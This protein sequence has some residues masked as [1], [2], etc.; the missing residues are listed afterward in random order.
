MAALLLSFESSKGLVGAY[1]Y[2]HKV[3]AWQYIDHIKANSFQRQRSRNLE[4]YTAEHKNR[5]HN[6]EPAGHLEHP[7]HSFLWTKL[8]VEY[9]SKKRLI[10]EGLLINLGI[11]VLINK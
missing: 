6:S 10:A 4:T 9:F 8:H 11:R 7:Q 5:R 1:L 2:I 3:N